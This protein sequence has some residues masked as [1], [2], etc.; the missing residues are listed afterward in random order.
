MAIFLPRLWWHKPRARA[1]GA[2]RVGI[3]CRKILDYG[4][5]TITANLIENL[6]AIDSETSYFLFGDPD[7]VGVKGPN[8]TTIK[9]TTK[10]YSIRESIRLPGHSQKLDLDLLHWLHYATSP[11]KRCKYVV[12]IH[13]INHLLLPELLSSRVHRKYA[14]QM[15][16]L[17]ARVADRIITAS[18]SSKKEII[19]HLHVPEEKVAVIHNGVSE[20]FKELPSDEVTASLRS[21]FGL[22]SPYIL[23]VG[24]LREHKNVRRLLEAFEIA[25]KRLGNNLSLVIAGEHRGQK[26]A[27]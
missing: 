5:G 9:E 18:N 16:R 12:S 13:D 22:E 19:E 10:R 8:F 17:S 26:A 20:A 25:R 21:D 3:D 7:V 24:S 27:L 1:E 11:I 6:A 23:Y 15:L 4:I 2:A 14:E